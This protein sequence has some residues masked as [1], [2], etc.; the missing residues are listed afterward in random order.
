MLPYQVSQPKLAPCVVTLCVRPSHTQSAC[1]VQPQVPA[2][3]PAK[4]ARKAFSSADSTHGGIP[5]SAEQ[6]TKHDCGV[7]PSPPR[8]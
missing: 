4:L 6:V 7:V 3:G 5:P 2:V 1:D 8:L